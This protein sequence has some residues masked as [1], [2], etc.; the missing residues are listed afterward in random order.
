VTPRPSSAALARRLLPV[1][2]A[3]AD[4]LHE[5]GVALCLVL[6]LAAVLTP[7]L[8]LFG[9][10]YGLVSTLYE[11]LRADPRNYE[12]VFVGN[13]RFDAGWLARQAGR[14]EVAFVVPRT[15]SLAATIDLRGPA[16]RSL[17]AVEMIPTAAGDPVLAFA[18]APVPAGPLGVVL[19]ASAAERLGARPG[20]AVAGFVARRIDGQPQASRVDLTVTAVLPGGALPREALFVGLPLLVATED[21]RDGRTAAVATAD[22]APVLAAPLGDRRF[23]S[24]RLFARDLDDVAPLAAGYRDEG[25]EVRTRAAE[26]ANV[27]AIDR[28]LDRLFLVIAGIGVSGYF[29]SLVASL[30][31]NVRRKRKELAVLRLIGFGRLAMIAVP[32]C[33]GLLTAALGLAVSFLA[34]LP[35]AWGLNLMFE[36][37]L[38]GG[39]YACRIE[40]WHALVAVSATLA[41]T[42][43]ATTAAILSVLAVDPAEDLREV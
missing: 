42:V 12:V 37:S 2:L 23:A 34:L 41:L 1:R 28:V 38:S 5:W 27:Q 3:A 7:L 43:V 22:G 25:L 33:Q 11:R 31:A 19:S 29:L 39:E 13:G 20:D 32:V 16:G 15:R 30:W 40:P 17:T 6:A 18:Q 14:P 10:K 8:T 9:L 35:I 24:V 21:Y 36:Q 4:Y 26:I